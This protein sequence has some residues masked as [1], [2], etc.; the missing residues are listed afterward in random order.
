MLNVITTASA[1][2]GDTTHTE[3]AFQNYLYSSVCSGV[4]CAL[5]SP[6][7]ML[8]VLLHKENERRDQGDIDDRNIAGDN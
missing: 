1:Q 2:I 6:R 7:F 8:S 5:P 4:R 3:L